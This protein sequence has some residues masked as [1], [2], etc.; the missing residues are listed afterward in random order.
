VNVTGIAENGGVEEGRSPQF[1]PA[2]QEIIDRLGR[3]EHG[4]EFEPELRGDLRAELEDR[5]SPIADHLDE[6]L[7]LSKRTVES[8]MGCERRALAE[9]DGSTFEWSAPLA[10]GTVAH[11]AIELSVH[12]R[13]QAA[14][15]ELVDD[16][17]ASLIQGDGSL[18]DWLQTCGDTVRAE[19]R[20]EANN[21]LVAF[22]DTWP[23]L[24]AKWR[25]VLEAKMRADLC[26]NRVT[27]AGKTD[28][29]IG[30]PPEGMVAT[31]V[32]VDFK[33]GRVS[34]S[35]AADLRLYALVETLRVGVPPR[36]V[37]THY[38]DSARLQPEVVTVD[39]LHAALDRVVD[40]AGRIATLIAGERDPVVR[41]GPACRWCPVLAD[42]EEGRSH[43]ADRDDDRSHLAEDDD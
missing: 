15:L 26:D 24:D 6:P 5:L 25:P 8:A 31:K 36:M 27:L 18:A 3:Q 33:T 2:Q 22:L 7:F 9:R 38:L 12:R 13:D 30:R 20:N 29:V 11:K 35:D 39:T 1:N 23:P 37:A 21:R 16:A 34:P 32:I 40:A 42:C 19:V 43:L 4:P 28:L 14:P 41:T 17:I 10:R